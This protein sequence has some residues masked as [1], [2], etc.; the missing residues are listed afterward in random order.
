MRIMLADAGTIGATF[1]VTDA[2]AAVVGDTLHVLMR[3][4]SLAYGAILT[5]LDEAINRRGEWEDA[6]SLRDAVYVVAM[7]IGSDLVCIGP[8]SK[9]TAKDVL[10]RVEVSFA[11]RVWPVD[12][13]GRPA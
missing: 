9:L 4:E 11:A 13:M 1:E 5:T 3:V 12:P 2:R 6:R 7:A 8:P 10:S